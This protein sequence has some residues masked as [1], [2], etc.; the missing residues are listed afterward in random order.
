M[1]SYTEKHGGA[2]GAEEHG[3]CFSI[4]RL[5]ETPFAPRLRVK[6]IKLPFDAST[7]FI[8]FPE[9]YFAIVFS[10]A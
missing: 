3:E 10:K 4:F 2:E 8:I 5:R 1:K 9:N 7:L 6:K